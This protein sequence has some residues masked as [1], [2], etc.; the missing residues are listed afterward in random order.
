M[1][2]TG[3]LKHQLAFPA[4]SC[5]GFD[6]IFFNGLLNGFFA[7]FALFGQSAQCSNGNVVAVNFEEAAQV[8][9]AVGATEAI[10][11]QD[12]V[13]VRDVGAD[14]VSIAADVVGSG[15]NRTVMTL[16]L[17]SN[18]RYFCSF[19]WVQT[20]EAFNFDGITVQLVE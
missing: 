20:I 17:R 7:D 19:Q 16:Q 1:K 5:I 9:T 11:T 3:R 8:G 14:T 6:A 4:R 15:N 10:G 13:V 2:Q 18:K 12:M